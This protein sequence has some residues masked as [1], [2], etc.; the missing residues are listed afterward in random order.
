MNKLLFLNLFVVGL[1]GFAS[2]R[3]QAQIFHSIANREKILI[4]DTLFIKQ[5]QNELL[6]SFYSLNQNKTAWLNDNGTRR[7]LLHTLNLCENEGLNAEEFSLQKLQA[8]EVKIDSLP[9][10]A[11]I[12]YD[13]LLT[14]QLQK[15]V[16]Q[17]SHGKIDPKTLYRDWDLKINVVDTNAQLLSFQNKDSVS[18]KINNLQPNHL[19]YRRLKTALQRL[20]SFPEDTINCIEMLGCINRNEVHRAIIPI[21]RKLMYWKDLPAATVL[22]SSYN[23]ETFI[24]IKKFQ[25]RHGLLADGVIGSRTLEALNFS[26]NRRREQIIANLERWKW[27]P[28]NLGDY[29]LIVNIPEYNL[30]VIK[31]NDTIVI[32]SIVVGTVARRTPILSSTFS[33]I[34]LNPTW[35][36]PP[37]ILEEDLVPSATKKGDYFSTRNISIYDAKNNVIS[38]RN[39]NAAK[40]KNYRYVQSPGDDN[41]LGNVKFNF[42]N[43]FSV[44]LHDTNHRDYFVRTFRSL[45][46]GC[47][48]IENPLPLAMYML[49]D[50]KRWSMEKICEVIASRKTTVVA[51]KQ[52]INI[53]QWYWTAWMNNEQQFEFR[54]D[55]YNLDEELYE[56]L[57][58]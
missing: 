17:M 27:F 2:N 53:H 16:G 19:V 26:K 33:M 39:W 1:V 43:K 34:V 48:R 50:S 14:L 49:N 29:Y 22:D 38:R 12:N 44:Y 35:T 7:F 57:R 24:A 6:T 36:V 32:K 18:K 40:Y 42:P 31:S 11:L 41:S 37:T 4:I 21:K 55:I 13:V 45:S 23:E 47:V 28:R 54:S 8:F 56:K 3:S 20:N 9:D 25:M 15:Y 30:K 46:S 10:D 51:L 58:K 52:N 5:F